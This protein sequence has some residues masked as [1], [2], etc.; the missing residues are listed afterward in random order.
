M[1]FVNIPV[2]QLA[3][4]LLSAAGVAALLGTDF[5]VFGEGFLRMARR[6]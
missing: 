1:S 6:V 5:G 2:R 3:A 4:R